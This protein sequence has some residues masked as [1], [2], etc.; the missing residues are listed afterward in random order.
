MGERAHFPVMAN[1][2]IERYTPS[3]D[4]WVKIEIDNTPNLAAF[5]W[6]QIEE[7]PK[8]IVLGGSNGDIMT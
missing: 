5:A 1:P 3:L 6:A 8:I 4:T 7:D 2:L